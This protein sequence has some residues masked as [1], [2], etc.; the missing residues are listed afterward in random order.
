M[1]RMP[2]SGVRISC[3]TIARK[4]DFARL[5]A[6]AWSRA[7]AS[8]RSACDAVGDVAADALH[9]GLLRPVRTTTS[10]H[11]IQ[12]APSALAI[13]WSCTRVP[14][15]WSAVSPCSI[16]GSAKASPTSSARGRAASAQNASL[17]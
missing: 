13:F 9:L 4:R 16:T 5:A 11:A 3:E 12:R 1:P 14:S 8:A 7:S 2:L 15:G 17:A 6:S 10:R